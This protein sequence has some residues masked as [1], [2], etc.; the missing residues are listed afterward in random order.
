MRHD[1]KGQSSLITTVLV[2]LFCLQC[3]KAPINCSRHCSFV[4]SSLENALK[5]VTTDVTMLVLEVAAMTTRAA[6]GPCRHRKDDVLQ[7]RSAVKL[8]P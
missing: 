6:N 2:P 5:S 1:I 3:K 4:S 7:N 8:C